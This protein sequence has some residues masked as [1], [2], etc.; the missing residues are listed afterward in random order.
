ME[1]MEKR[2]M[3]AMEKTVLAQNED[4]EKRMMEAMKE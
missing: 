4:M 3:E 2:M 1:A